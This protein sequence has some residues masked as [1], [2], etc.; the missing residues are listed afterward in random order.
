MKSGYD[1]IVIGGGHAG[2]EAAWAAS[3]LG[4]DVALV[5]MDPARMGQMSC[6]PAIGGLAKG[7][8]VREIDALGG[9]MGLA[10]DDTGIQ[11]RMLNRSRGPAV[12]GPR[13]QADKYKYAKRV[14]ELL[15]GCGRGPKD[16]PSPALPRSTGGGG[17]RVLEI[18]RG[19]VAEICAGPAVNGIVLGDGTRLDCRAVIVTTG[20]FLRA[21]MH[22]GLTQTPGGRVGESAAVGL[23]ASLQ[24]LGL[25]MGR[26]KTGTPPRIQKQSIDFSRLEPQPGDEAPAPFS[27][28]NEYR[29]GWAPPLRQVECWITATGPEVHQIIRENLHRAPMYS[30]QIQ[31]T[32]PRYCPSIEDKVVRFADK[33][34]HHIFLEPE[35]LDTDEIYCNGISTS[36]PGDVQ[37]RIVRLIPGLEAAK[38]LRYGYAV[39]YD[40]VWPTQIKSTLETKR[41]PGLFLAG[42]INGTSGYEEAAAQ[43]L[44]AGINAARY[45]RGSGPDFVLRR[46]QAYIGVLIDDLVTKPPTEP[47]RMF[48]SRAEHRLLLR[49]DN[50]DERLTPVGR[51]IGLVNDERWGMFSSRRDALAAGEQMVR[52]LRADEMLRRPDVQ[53]SEVTAR[54]PELGAIDLAVANLL[55]IRARYEGYIA[56][57]DR[58]VQRMVKLE[59]TLIPAGTDYLGVVGLRNEAKQKFA[60]FT[61][62]SLGQALRISGITPADVTV[63]AIHLDRR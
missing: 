22:T 39:E 48:T 17:Q 15:G 5:T 31:S 20:T 30:G 45:A 37:E 51:E 46:D 9:L 13:A 36:L 23:S 62:R 6:N 4:A 10:T 41:V 18:V 8:I 42:Q 11:F 2:A 57:Q 34:S 44:V 1:I 56:R 52:Q 14:Q 43:G 27:Y 33:E 54:W 21:L 24:K 63:L 59:S 32:G 47:Y 7:Q 60:R 29:G 61:P 38:I 26:L 25:E 19:E 58:D 28:L 53:W 49:S 16:A 55:Q 35:G 50:A 40:M 3:G 12:W